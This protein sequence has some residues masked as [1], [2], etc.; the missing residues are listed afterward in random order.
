MITAQ[1]LSL[2]KPLKIIELC[3]MFSNKRC[4][5]VH[6]KV[7]IYFKTGPPVFVLMQLALMR[8]CSAPTLDV[9]VCVCVHACVRACVHVCDIPM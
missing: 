3:K 4:A 5:S 6:T 1:Q 8:I 2:T 7:H 9:C